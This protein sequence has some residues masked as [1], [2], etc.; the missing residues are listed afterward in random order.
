MHHNSFSYPRWDKRV[1]YVVPT[2]NCP[3]IVHFRVTNPGNL[4]YT[5]RHL[6]DFL[7]LG[8]Y[9]CASVSEKRPRDEPQGNS[10]L[11]NFQSGSFAISY[12]PDG[13]VHNYG[14]HA[15]YRSEGLDAARYVTGDIISIWVDSFPKGSSSPFSAAVSCPAPTSRVN[16]DAASS[17]RILFCAFFKNGSLVHDPFTLA[18]LVLPVFICVYFDGSL[19]GAPA[20]ERVEIVEA[21]FKL[22]LEIRNSSPFIVSY[23]LVKAIIKYIF[24]LSS[25]PS[26]SVSTK[27]QHNTYDEYSVH[28]T[29]F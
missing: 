19:N 9:F 18:G 20:A 8:Y 16:L 7:I 21:P 5:D 3:E 17:D 6:T 23:L 27:T 1:A 4:R 14:T 15:Q 28:I 24:H 12:Y 22:S 26:I 10:D 25:R 2:G 13:D 11:T 29:L